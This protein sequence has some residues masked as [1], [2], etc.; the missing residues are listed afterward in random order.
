MPFRRTKSRTRTK[1]SG[2]IAA[3]MAN[4]AN[5]TMPPEIPEEATNEWPVWLMATSGGTLVTTAIVLSALARFVYRR[6]EPAHP[7]YAVLL[8]DIVFLACGAWACVMAGTLALAVKDKVAAANTVLVV[9]TTP[10]QFNQVSWLV[11]NYL[12]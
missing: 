8:Q 12:R 6:M 9:L 10:I 4:S 7:L 1:I 3:T 11:I 2:L 5:S